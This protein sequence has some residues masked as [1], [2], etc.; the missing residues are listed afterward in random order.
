MLGAGEEFAGYTV[1]RE[2]GS[3]GMGEVYLA[4]HPRLPR[5]EA[6]KILRPEISADDSFRQRFIREADSIAALE[7]PYIV[8]VHDRGD[9]DGRLWIATQFIDGSDAARLLGERYPAGMPADDVAAIATAIAD[10]LDYA[11]DRGMLHRD[12]KPANI[13]LTQ[14]DHDGHRRV[15]LADFGIARPLDD[16]AGL[17]ATNFTVGTIAYAAP[18]QL[19]GNPMDGRADQYALAATAYHLVTGQ[20]VYPDSNP[21]AVISRHLAKPPPPPSTVRADLAPLDRVFARALAKNPEDRFPCCQD[22]SGAFTAAVGPAGL[23][24]SAPTQEAP[25]PAEP[26]TP[27]PVNVG[28]RRGPLAVGV[29]TSVGIL[30]L[31]VGG[32]LWWRPWETRDQLPGSATAPS[33]ITTTTPTLASVTPPPSATPPPPSTT[34]AAAVPPAAQASDPDVLL[35]CKALLHQPT[36]A[37]NG[38]NQAYQELQRVY[39]M[40]A[41]YADALVDRLVVLGTDD[42][43]GWRPSQTCFDLWHAGAIN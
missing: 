4:R 20:P 6:L 40:E 3:G 38:P 10:A 34:T 7:H 5:H 2:I 17:T 15:Y 9:T 27:T 39:G 42:P 41:N 16:P 35:A 8:T 14:P 12:V 26:P 21:V 33:V 22:F 19:M 13:L 30:G 24:A 25:V 18:E 1:V 36:T 29:L 32:A 37:Y 28:R 43:A 31:L 11:H 23:S